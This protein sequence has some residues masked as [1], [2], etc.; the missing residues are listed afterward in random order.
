MFDDDDDETR[1]IVS[2]IKDGAIVLR[3]GC[4][5]VYIYPTPQ[6]L[7]GSEDVTLM[8]EFFRWCQDNKDVVEDFIREYISFQQDLDNQYEKKKRALQ[9]NKLRLVPDEKDLDK[10]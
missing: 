6:H 4:K 10:D 5:P 2:T 8:L 1:K 7:S 9:K 3:R